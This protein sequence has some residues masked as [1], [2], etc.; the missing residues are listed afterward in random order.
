MTHRIELR[1]YERGT[2]LVGELAH[3][4]DEVA[5]ILAALHLGGKSLGGRFDQLGSR[6]VTP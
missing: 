6:S 1:E 4:Y 5:Q 2:L 3:V